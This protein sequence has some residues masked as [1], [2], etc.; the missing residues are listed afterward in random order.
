MKSV[1]NNDKNSIDKKTCP[2]TGYLKR[3][4]EADT[5]QI[6]LPFTLLETFLCVLTL[7]FVFKWM[8]LTQA[9]RAPQQIRNMCKFHPQIWCFLIFGAERRSGCGRILNYY[10]YPNSLSCK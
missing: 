6:V 8:F 9:E 7:L 4:G 1:K 10:V 2:H 5:T 3:K